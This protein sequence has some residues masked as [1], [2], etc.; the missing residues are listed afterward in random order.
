MK[1][2]TRHDY[3]QRIDR[4]IALLQ[5][6]VEQGVELPELSRLAAAA[7]LSPFHFHRIYRALS[8]ETV[9]QTVARLRLL[10]A[11]HLLTDPDGRVTETALAIGYDTPQAFARAFRQAFDASP[12]EMRGQGE[13]LQA[14][15]ERLRRPP[16]VEASQVALKVEVVSVDPFRVMAMR[17]TGHQVDLDRA[18]ERLFQWAAAQGVLE[19]M[20][21]I[22]GVPHDEVRETPAEQC[23]FDCALAFTG[24]AFEGDA[25]VWPLALGG[26][27]WAR[28]RHVGSYNALDLATDRFIA[29][30]LPGS[31]HALRDELPFRHFLDDPEQTPEAVLRAD[32]YLPVEAC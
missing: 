4:V 14:E 26:G 8:G 12:S 9:G 10:R 27:T 17:Y 30:W 7:H 31:G 21:G 23:R 1:P 20:A 11:L 29:D 24:D 28:C 5:S 32:I 18:Y 16:A 22:Y 15:I 6:S 3:L 13:R 25:L 19:R 2:S